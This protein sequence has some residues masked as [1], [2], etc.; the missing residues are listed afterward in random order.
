ME[1]KKKSYVRDMTDGNV[2]LHMVAF[3]LPM[4]AGNMFQQLYNMVDSIIVGRFVGANALGAVGS[5]GAL[6]FLCFSLCLGLSNGIGILVSQF[7]G[8]G[9]DEKVKTYIAHAVY[10]I[11]AAGM[12]MSLI[13]FLFA[14]PI[15]GMMKTPEETFA[16]ALCYMKIVCG[17]SVVVA[18]FNGISAILR[19]LGDSKTPLI[20]L[21]IASIVNIAL[22][23][24]FV[25]YLHMDVAGAAYATIISQGIA[26]GGSVLWGIRTNPYLRLHREHFIFDKNIVWR[27]IVMGI[28]LSAQAATIS[29]SCIALQSVVNR[30]GA[31]IMAAYT[32]SNRIEQ[33]VQQPLNSLGMASSTIAGQNFGAGKKDRIYSAARSGMLINFLFAVL[34]IVVMYTLGNEIVGIFIADSQVIEIGAS[35]LRITSCMYLFLGM[36]YVYRGLLNGVGDVNFSMMNGIAEVICRISFALIL[37]GMLNFNYMAV[38]YTNGL[39]WTIVGLF[40]VVR[41]YQAKW[42]LKKV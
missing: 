17:F 34:M 23:V 29:V 3:A 35:G 2:M 33:L 22:D 4:L 16:D 26:A 19:A 15:L 41:F 21:G 8:A 39:T 30:F 28:P 6:N 12:L 36:I 25:V 9:E 5:V 18:I 10:V 24:L 14:E 38:W 32:A 40:S 31:T 13:S 7:F 1:T 11:L 42:S 27:E 20:F 37:I